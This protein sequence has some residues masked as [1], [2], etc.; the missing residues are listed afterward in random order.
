MQNITPLRDIWEEPE[1]NS[2]AVKM[3]KTKKKFCDP[4][5]SWVFCWFFFFQR[6]RKKRTTKFYILD[7]F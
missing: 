2:N 7:L 4:N 3:A 5:P 1:N 6:V